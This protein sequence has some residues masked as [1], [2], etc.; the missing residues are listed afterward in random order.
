MHDAAGLLTP[1]CIHCPYLAAPPVPPQALV[2]RV[3]GDP[4]FDVESMDWDDVHDGQP[5]SVTRFV[6]LWDSCK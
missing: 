6:H 4:L 5:P 1:P 3:Q 2:A